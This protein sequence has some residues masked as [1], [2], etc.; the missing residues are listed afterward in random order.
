MLE[1][2]LLRRIIVANQEII[3]TTWSVRWTVLDLLDGSEY[4]P[5]ELRHAVVFQA[6]SWQIKEF[7]KSTA[8]GIGCQYIFT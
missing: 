4:R 8:I 5:T 7:Y 6:N 3:G 2:Y 1:I